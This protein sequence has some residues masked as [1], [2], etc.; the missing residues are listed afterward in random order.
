[1]MMGES[2][3]CCGHHITIFKEYLQMPGIPVN[4]HGMPAKY[5]R[6]PS[7]AKDSHCKSRVVTV[8]CGYCMQGHSMPGR[9]TIG[10]GLPS[11]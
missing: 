7:K 11:I 5:H 9:H 2:C 8:C 4:T 1:M 10:H 3:E 6:R